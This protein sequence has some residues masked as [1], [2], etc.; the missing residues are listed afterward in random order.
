MYDMK[1]IIE[2]ENKKND[3][4]KSVSPVN[5]SLSETTEERFNRLMQESASSLKNSGKII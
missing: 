2:N 1:W 4:P 3:Y 5:K